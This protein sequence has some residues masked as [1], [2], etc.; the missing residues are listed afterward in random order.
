M[1]NFK[2]ITKLANFNLIPSLIK[3]DNALYR[4]FGTMKYIK[5]LADKVDGFL[6][7][8]TMPETKE[9]TSCN[10]GCNYC[11]FNKKPIF[12]IHGS[13]KNKKVS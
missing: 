9:T 13:G 5:K 3:A 8:A 10:A 11:V 12:L 4:N 2:E 6:C 1:F 7:P